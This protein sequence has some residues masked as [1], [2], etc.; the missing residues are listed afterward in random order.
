MIPTL[1]N[2]RQNLKTEDRGI[3]KPNEIGVKI[4]RFIRRTVV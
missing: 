1:K 4:C 3:G 2:K